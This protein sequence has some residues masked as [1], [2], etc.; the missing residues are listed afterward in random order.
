MARRWARW[1]LLAAALALFSSIVVAATGNAASTAA[2]APVTTPNPRCGVAG[3]WKQS[4]L[5]SLYVSQVPTGTPEPGGYTWE[6]LTPCNEVQM[7][8]PCKFFESSHVS[9]PQECYDVDTGMIPN[10]YE[11]TFS[12]LVATTYAGRVWLIG[13]EPDRLDQDNITP[14]QYARMYHYYYNLIKAAD[15]SATIATAGF[16]HDPSAGDVYTSGWRWASEVLTAYQATYSTTMPIDVWNFHLYNDYDYE[17]TT[18]RENI[19]EWI[20]FIETTRDGTY[21]TTQVWLTEWGKLDGWVEPDRSPED[22]IHNE[23]LH[24]DLVR[25]MWDWAEW[26]EA[27]GEIDRWFWF[28]GGMGDWNLDI[29]FEQT[30]WLLEPE[31]DYFTNTIEGDSTTTLVDPSLPTP[32][33]NTIWVGATLFVQHL[34]QGRKVTG[35]DPNNDTLTVGEPFPGA[36]SGTYGLLKFGYATPVPNFLG[37]AYAYF[38]NPGVFTNTLHL[39]VT[40]REDGGDRAAGGDFF[41]SPLATPAALESP[42]ATPT[43]RPAAT[44]A[45]T[46]AVSIDD[47]NYWDSP[48]EHG[49]IVLDAGGELRTHNYKFDSPKLHPVGEWGTHANFRFTFP[50][51][52]AGGEA[53]ALARGY[54][55][56]EVGDID[57]WWA[58]ADVR[59]DD[60]REYRL[61]YEPRFGAT[62]V[63]TED[64]RTT[65]V[66]PIGEGYAEAGYFQDVGRNLSADL[67][68]GVPG[69]GVALVNRLT[70]YGPGYLDDVMLQEPAFPDD[71]TPPVT[72]VRLEGTLGSQGWYTSPVRMLLSARDEAGGSGVNEAYYRYNGMPWELNHDH[73]S[74]MVRDGRGLIEGYVVDRAGNV[75]EVVTAELSIDQT[76]PVVRIEA[77]VA[78]EYSPE[79]TLAVAYAAE[80]A[81]SGVEQVVVKLDGVELGGARQLRTWTLEPGLHTLEVTAADA[82]GW[83]TSARRTFTVS[84]W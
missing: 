40:M 57:G 19:E 54:L 67:S 13:N 5:Q 74:L 31:I 42:L 44:P 34:V 2:V 56:F 58:A 9:P 41:S 33:Q 37:G 80:D 38:C 3:V 35:Y 23:K 7:V 69:V 76:P 66:H 83:Q 52:P 1:F 53:L 14:T 22:R 61:R 47:F 10:G 51:D 15:P 17:F 43:P 16:S 82:A 6:A 60:G 4:V 65:V 26:M 48:T 75:E 77:P 18:V 29:D 73:F 11:S 84:G 21:S 55:S 59:G 36:V 27:R 62:E 71:N 20:Y 72:Q 45:E 64:G 70:F 63:L 32:E 50:G 46:G 49:W 25:L 12:N 28:V 39:P 79:S 30:A 24:P 8:R 68:A 81:T 78:G